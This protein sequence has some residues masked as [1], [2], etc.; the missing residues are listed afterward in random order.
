MTTSD[1]STQPQ[2]ESDRHG[3]ARDRD[4]S[5]HDQ[6]EKERDNRDRGVHEQENEGQGPN[7]VGD[8]SHARN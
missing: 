1:R 2:K 5:K 3:G 6:F 4:A 8:Q 7:N